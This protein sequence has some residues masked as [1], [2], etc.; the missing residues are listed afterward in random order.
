MDTAQIRAAV[1]RRWQQ[2]VLPSLMDFIRIPAI[3]PLFD[4]RWE[5]KGHIEAALQLAA[6][7]CRAQPI[8]GL[9]LEVVRLPGRTPLLFIEIPGQ[10]D[11]TVLLYGHLDKQPEMVGWRE[12][13]GPWQPV[14][15]GDKLYGRGSVDDGYAMYTALTALRV[16][17]EQGVPHARCVGIIECCEESGSYDLPYYID[18]LAPRIGTPS[19]VVGLDSGCGDYERLW[20]TVSLRGLING[21]LTVDVLTEGVHSGDASGTVPSGFRI[22]RRLLSRLE[23]EETG[24][25]LP[26]AFHR[27]IPPERVAQAER[28]AEVL[29]AAVYTKFP[30]VSGMEPLSRDPKELILNR[31]W[32]PALSVTGAGGLP[33]L[34]NA[35]NVLR[36]HTAL[37]LSLR[38]PPSCEP[39]VAAAELKTLLESDPPYGARVEFQAEQAAPGWD[40]APLAPWFEAAL[41]RASQSYFGKEAVFMGE[42]VTIP[43]MGMLGE[44][45]PGA[46]FLITGVLGPASN[47]HG[48]NEFLH[49][50][51]AKALTCCVAEVLAA[52]GKRA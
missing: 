14:I 49:L 10:T 20:C 19:L 12:D 48:P 2:D 30:F 27:P 46:Q 33:P 9:Q 15:E 17:Q 3:S 52:H 26:E 31:A 18:L 25:I 29:G 42:G 16:L 40:A 13:L 50:P 35:G 28:A 39:Q 8:A 32:K 47:A 5:E 38:L 34:D 41:E 21:N 37:K 36:P 43:F 7:W 45:F 44:R 51:A 11:G 23:D 4:S 1:E 6:A 24:R 22:A